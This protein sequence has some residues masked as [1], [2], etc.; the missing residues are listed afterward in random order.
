MIT[1]IKRDGKHLKKEIYLKGVTIGSGR[2]KICVSLVGNSMERLI[3]EAKGLRSLE[4]DLVEWRVDFFE[5]NSN[6]KLVKEALEEIRHILP[7]IP[8]I[9]TFRTEREGGEKQL[10][11]VDYFQLNKEIMETDNI[12]LI[13]IELFTDKEKRKTLIECAHAN[14]LAVIVS[15]HDFDKTPSKD[16]II[17]RLCLAE[18]INGDIA[19]IAVMPCSAKD[20]ITLLDATET[21][22]RT[23]AKGPIIT[24]SMGSMGVVSRIAG[25]IFG[26][27]V[28]FAAAKQVSA[29]GQIAVTELDQI[30][31]RL[32]QTKK[33]I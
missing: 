28:T 32:K 19:K 10:K 31:K 21:M 9:F 4:I 23:Y 22:Y 3:E 1:F 18:E 2:P 6:V 16:E 25:E 30:L 14:H 13:D 5:D 27:A 29:P 26:S 24:M 8:L 15:N 11:I 20:V 17:S 7:D 33:E 12:D